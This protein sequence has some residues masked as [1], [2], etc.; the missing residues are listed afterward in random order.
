MRTMYQCVPEPLNRGAA[1]KYSISLQSNDGSEKTQQTDTPVQAIFKIK[2]VG[3]RG[4][5]FLY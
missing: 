1:F 5:L 3:V 2:G 4:E